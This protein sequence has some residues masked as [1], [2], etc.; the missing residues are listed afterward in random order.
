MGLAWN[1]ESL[2][3]L[4]DALYVV[5]VDGTVVQSHSLPVV[6]PRG[7]AWDGQAVVM[8]SRGPEGV[9]NSG[10]KLNR[11]SLDDPDA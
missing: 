7:L 8:F 5:N 6:Y 4:S 1:G 2:L 9:G 3:I 11:F 10:V